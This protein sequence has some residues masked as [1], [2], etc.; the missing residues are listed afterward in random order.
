MFQGDVWRLHVDGASNSRGAGAG[1]VIVSPE[2]VMHEN[3]LTIGFTASNNE[4]EYEALVSGLKMAKHLGA[5]TV[6]VYSDSQLIVKQIKDQYSLKDPRMEKYYDKVWGLMEEI[7]TVEIEWVGRERNAHADTLASLATACAASPNRT[8]FLGELESPSIEHERKEVLHVSLGPSWMDEIY[9]YLKNEKL[10]TDKKE[11]HRVRCKAFYFY[12]D[13]SNQM[14]RRSFTG[15]DLKVPFPPSSYS[16]V[17][18]A[19]DEDDLRRICQE[20]RTMPKARLSPSP[21]GRSPATNHQPVA[22]CTMGARSS[23]KATDNSRRL[24]TLNN[25]N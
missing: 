17:L 14:Y 7:G 3:A 4:A 21:A 2:G 18:V 25:S 11:A 22:L 24:Q 23:G 15:P 16:R 12:L 1:I 5:E 20:M 19:K 13:P 10:P 8:I 6:Q 9:A